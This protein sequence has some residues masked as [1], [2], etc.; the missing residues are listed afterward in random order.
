MANM[1][2]CRFENTYRDLVD[3]VT[4]LEGVVYNEE[5]ISYSELEYAKRMREWCERFVSV[6]DDLDE[7][8][9]RVY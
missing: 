7:T 4:A 8:E 5:R 1:S 9:V 6:M 3:C 2:Y